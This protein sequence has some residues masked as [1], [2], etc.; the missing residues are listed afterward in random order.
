MQA[1]QVVHPAPI[2]T[3]PLELAERTIPQPSAREVLVRV[4]CC[5]ICRT[6]LHIVEGD[7]PPRA[8][9]VVPGH[10]IVGIVEA[11]GEG[12][13]RFR[14]GDRIGIAWLRYT[15][16]QCR[17]CTRELENLCPDARFTGWD[18]DGGYAEYAVVDERYAYPL[19]DSFSNEDA[20]PLLC[21]GIIGYR[22]LRR[23]QV[24]Q[25]GRLG[26]YG[27]GA[28]AHIT[29]QIAVHEDAVVHVAT[30]SKRAQELALELGAASVG[31]PLDTPPKPLDAAILFAPS[32]KLVP[33]ALEALAPGGTLSIAGIHLS[34][35]P[36]LDYAKHLFNERGIVSVTANTRSDGEEF[37]SLAASIPVKVITT[38][39]DLS[40]AEAGLIALARGEISGTG[41]VHVAS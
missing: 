13:S 24:P 36:E 11:T 38:P 39:F 10:Q 26:I 17:F 15:C 18:A 35:I 2:E 4:R 1:W 16:G 21:A 12:A 25:G 33:V 7:L 32:G 23:A 22:A 14:I 20:A 6:D 29:A 3:H 31:Q 30:R 37:L 27:F 9:H 8:S 40:E 41:V 28:S 34:P 5:G 19:P